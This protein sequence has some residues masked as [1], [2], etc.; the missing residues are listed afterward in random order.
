[1]L[2][3]HLIG[4]IF[5]DDRILANVISVLTGLQ[6]GKFNEETVGWALTQIDNLQSVHKAK[7]YS[8]KQVTSIG[9]AA[10]LRTL[11]ITSIVTRKKLRS[12]YKSISLSLLSDI[13]AK[14]K[15]IK[16]ISI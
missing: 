8:N 10:F 16:L 11:G 4:S 15:S 14:S 13:F 3:L 2:P 9:M 6:Q 1:M 5:L 12:Q 7:F